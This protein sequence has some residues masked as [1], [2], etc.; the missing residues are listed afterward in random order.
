M[1]SPSTP[2]ASSV[3]NSHSEAY[4]EV[5]KELAKEAAKEPVKPKCWRCCRKS[6]T[7][8]KNH[9][10][11]LTQHEI[12]YAKILRVEAAQKRVMEEKK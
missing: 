2:Y 6:K 4:L 3:M 12:E 1:S 5:R 10:R 9:Q 8:P 7:N 11:E